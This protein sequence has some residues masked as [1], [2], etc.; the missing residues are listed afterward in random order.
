MAPGGRTSFA[1]YR[2][3][4][5]SGTGQPPEVP[6]VPFLRKCRRRRMSFFRM[7]ER[8]S[9]DQV[10]LCSCAERSPARAG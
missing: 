4:V 2:E 5:R 3:R 7:L 10:L 9:D 8:L 6:M 1:N